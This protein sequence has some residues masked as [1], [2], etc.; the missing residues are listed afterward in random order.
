MIQESLNQVNLAKP[1]SQP[2]STYK[3]AIKLT[4]FKLKKILIDKINSSESYLTA[5]EY[6]ECYDG[7]VKYYNLDKDL[8]SSYDVYSLKHSRDDKEKDKGP[9]AGSGRGL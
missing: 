8:F 6:W 1:S 2:Q 7:L 5:P 4:K 9:F 3:V